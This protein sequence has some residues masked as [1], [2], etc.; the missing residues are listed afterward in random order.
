MTVRSYIMV[1][2]RQLPDSDPR[3]Q[4]LH[5]LTDE[6]LEGIRTLEQV[7]YSRSSFGPRSRRYR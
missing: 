1:H 7:A 5:W 3:Q 2:P 6:Q 4:A